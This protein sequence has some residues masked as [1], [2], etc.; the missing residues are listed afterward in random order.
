MDLGGVEV[1]NPVSCVYNVV[2]D[3][4][5]ILLVNGIECITW[6][7]DL[8]AEGVRHPYYGS[9]A[10]INDLKQMRGWPLVTISGCTKTRRGQVTSVQQAKI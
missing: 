10:I 9:A 2:L 4:C 3:R 5:H 1:P 6:G 8:T 7:H